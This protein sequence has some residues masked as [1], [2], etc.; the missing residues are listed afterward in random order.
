MTQITELDSDA[1]LGVAGPVLRAVG[2][3]TGFG[4]VPY[5]RGLDL[6]VAAGEVLAL[7]GANGAGKTTTLMALAGHL[8]LVEGH[9]ELDGEV[10]QHGMD[11]RARKGVAVVTQE[12]CVF[13]GLS[14]RD[15]LRLGRGS[16]EDALALFPE[17]EPHLHRH[18]GLLSGGQQQILAVAR[19]LAG[20]PKVLLADEISL[21]LAP[22]IVERLLAAVADAARTMGMAVVLVEQHVQQALSYAD[23]GVILQ[24]GRLQLESTSADLL[25]R[26]DEVAALYL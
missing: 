14:V 21:G 19:A 12:R 22:L 26:K 13:M 6:E 16:I 17:L 2:I 7:L 18:V 23:R 10:Q 9:V 25:R 8:R 11:E 5:V 3:T 4:A 20:R 15:N 24:R 1:R